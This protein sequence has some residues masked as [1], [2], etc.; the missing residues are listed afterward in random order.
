MINSLDSSIA[1]ILIVGG[2]IV[3]LATAWQLISQFPDKKIIVLEKEAGPAKHQ[4]GRNSG[5]LHS[6]I[7][8]RPGSL[9]AVNCRAGREAMVKFCVEHKIKHEVCG[10]VIVA[11]SEAECRACKRFLSAAKRTKCAAG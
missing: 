9:R 8:Y 6:G 4:S 10:K 11:T 1:E 5:V 3:G 7:Y 2:G